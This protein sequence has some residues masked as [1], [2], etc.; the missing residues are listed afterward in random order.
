MSVAI[1]LITHQ[2]IASSLLDV[3]S[4]IVNDSPTNI[5]HIEIP[6]DAPLT[7]MEKAI[8]FKL[9]QLDLQDGVLILTDMYGGTPSNL[10]NKFINLVNTKMVSGLNLPMMIKIMNYR[11]LPLDELTDKALSGG[12]DSIC[13][14]E[15]ITH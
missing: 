3:A 2:R 10:A 6:M 13:L 14:H 5:D 12:K 9:N 15:G 7:D 11:N 4:T 1:L 8:H